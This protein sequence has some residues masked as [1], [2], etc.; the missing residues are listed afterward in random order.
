LKKPWRTV[1]STETMDEAI[2]NAKYSVEQ[3]LREV[4][5]FVDGLHV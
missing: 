1:I 4:R 3:A 2:L 5:R